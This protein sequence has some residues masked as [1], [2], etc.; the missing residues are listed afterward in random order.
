MYGLITFKEQ[1]GENV[2]LKSI[3][4]VTIIL[5]VCILIPW[6]MTMAVTGVVKREIS[7][8]GQDVRRVR[9]DA[10]KTVMEVSVDDYIAG[11]LASRLSYGEEVE[12]LK[13][14]AIMVRT[15]IYA[16]MGDEICIEDDELSMTYLS[17]KERRKLW[18]SEYDEKESLIEDCISLVSNLAIQ[19]D[20]SF[21]NCPY[22]PV[23]AG[24]TRDGS[25]S[26]TEALNYLKPVECS[27][28][29]QAE[30][31]L[32]VLTKS[33]DDFV[34]LCNK[35]FNESTVGA[36]TGISKNAPLE[37]VQIV[38]RDASDYVNKVKV[39]SVIVT[40]EELADAL[41]LASPCFYFES[42]KDQNGTQ[43]VRITV[44]G[45][46]SGYGMSLNEAGKMASDGKNYE[47]IL[48]YFYSG[49]TVT[50]V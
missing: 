20:G 43:C 46:G 22:T 18:G 11:V 19:Y 33:N 6:S 31:F 30:N 49:I 50:D 37:S 3:Q 8:V 16:E 23:S 10:G 15:E 34:R 4:K 39:G 32:C 44:K 29:V 47:E 41:G 36:D 35:R 13:A 24:R 9:V 17:D 38:S 14:E 12:L 25:N 2:R 48:K 5:S 7:D 45:S 21:I 28:D 40:G 42:A 27:Y 1:G 26:K